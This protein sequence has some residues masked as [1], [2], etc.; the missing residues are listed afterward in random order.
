[1]NDGRNGM[2]DRPANQE[3]TVRNGEVLTKTHESE[4]PILSS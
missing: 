4:K 3:Q 2:M 1:M